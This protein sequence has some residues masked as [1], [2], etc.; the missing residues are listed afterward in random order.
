L[1]PQSLLGRIAPRWTIALRRPGGNDALAVKFRVH[2]RFTYE[3]NLF[4]AWLFE[5]RFEGERTFDSKRNYPRCVA[6]RHA[7]REDSGGAELYMDRPPRNLASARACQL[8]RCTMQ[9]RIQVIVDD[10]ERTRR[11]VA[12]WERELLAPET[13][14][15]PKD[16]RS[17]SRRPG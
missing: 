14:E 9:I 13:G 3:Y 6:G 8:R 15:R 1:Y 5:I 11:D 17:E 2:E 4:D 7:P 10:D 12:R 16:S